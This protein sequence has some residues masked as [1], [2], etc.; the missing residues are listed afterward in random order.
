MDY[1]L[2]KKIPR[3]HCSRGIFVIIV[4]KNASHPKLMLVHQFRT[5]AFS[6]QLGWIIIP[7][8]GYVSPFCV[9]P[10][11]KLER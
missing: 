4:V 7:G 2:Q 10:S 6:F 11:L 3:E 8:M 9:E 5:E 1:V